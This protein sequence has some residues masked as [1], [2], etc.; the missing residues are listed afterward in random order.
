MGHDPAYMRK[1]K[2]RNHWA[3]ACDGAEMLPDETMKDK[4]GRTWTCSES[5][6]VEKEEKR[7]FSAKKWKE[8][9]KMLKTLIPFLYEAAIKTFVQD[10]DGAEVTE[11]N[12][13]IGKSGGVYECNAG[14]LDGIV[15]E[16]PTPEPCETLTLKDVCNMVEMFTGSKP[17][18]QKPE[19]NPP[20]YRIVIECDG[21]D[22]T[23][24]EM[25]V[26]GK[27]VRTSS[28]KRNPEDRFD[29][30]VGAEYAF[31]RLFKKEE[32]KKEDPF[33]GFKVGDRVICV[34]SYDGN[35][36]IRGRHGTIRILGGEYDPNLIGIEFDENV[37]GHDFDG[38]VKG[39][40]DKHC[41]Y[42][43]VSVLKHE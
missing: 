10:C 41:W 15:Y 34:D 29:F 36:R 22:V 37:C 25:V 31:E 1:N 6:T 7:W 43:T 12:E 2:P 9:N 24:A 11:D 32:P 33:G 8:E 39:V 30:K 28:A 35:S 19:E 23:T 27:L 17:E 38:R 14:K 3:I 42:C 18:E 16:K 40:K 20:R 13:I 5:W 21:G 4:Y 26:N